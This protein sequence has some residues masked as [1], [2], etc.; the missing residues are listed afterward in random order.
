VDPR[1]DRGTF[2][3][4]VAE[5]DQMPEVRLRDIRRGLQGWKVRGR[6]R[7]VEWV[8]APRLGAGLA[9]PVVGRRVAMV[10]SSKFCT[11]RHLE[12]Y[13]D[14]LDLLDKVATHPL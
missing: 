2:L 10:R 7:F 8:G 11:G 14:T 4:K 5:A 9:S 1:S 13:R 6:H 3:D 12:F